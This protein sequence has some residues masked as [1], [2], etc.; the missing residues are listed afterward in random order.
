VV[1]PPNRFQ[2]FEYDL[3]SGLVR[4]LT[5]DEGSP[6]VGDYGP[7]RRLVYG[8]LGR[9][10]RG[11]RELQM[12]IY[13]TGPYG[14]S[15]ELLLDGVATDRLAWSPLGSPVL[16]VRRDMR[17][18]KARPNIVAREPVPGSEEKDLAP[19][20]DPVFTPDGAWIV[21]SGPV[22]GG[23]KLRRMR[24]DG[25]GRTGLGASKR[26]EFEPAVSPD[27][28]YVAYIGR[29][30]SDVDRLYVRRMDGSGDRILLRS[31]GA[32]SPAW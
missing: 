8:S 21:Y 20:R 17:R 18:S 2:L 9:R 32:A 1:E 28:K 15:P 14:A 31:G 11:S 23:W 3:E 12:N 27:G 22:G 13:L 19:G 10:R 30:V 6:L 25:S 26:D 29:E 24:P 7:D 4:R 5:Y 16:Y